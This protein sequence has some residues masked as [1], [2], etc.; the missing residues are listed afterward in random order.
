MNTSVAKNLLFCFLGLLL[1]FPIFSYYLQIPDVIPLQGFVQVFFSGPGLIAL[2]IFMFF[3]NKQK[4][5]G[6]VFFVIG[7]CWIGVMLHEVLTK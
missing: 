3:Y 2:G 4:I 1:L 7:L 5:V 6:S